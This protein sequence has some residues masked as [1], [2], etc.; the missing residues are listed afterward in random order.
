MPPD[1]IL[2]MASPSS[3]RTIR[4]T[5]GPSFSRGPGGGTNGVVLACNDTGI[6]LWPHHVY[7]V[8][9]YFSV[10]VYDARTVKNNFYKILSDLDEMNRFK[11]DVPIGSC[12]VVAYTI[13]TWGKGSG[14][15]PNISFN[16]KWAMILGTPGRKA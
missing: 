13:N 6:I 1:N 11:G 8:L 15:V 5:S 7:L 16:I 12:V 14:G 4:R 3:N 9:I 2:V 10:P